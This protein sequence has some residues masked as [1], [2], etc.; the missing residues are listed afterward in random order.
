MSLVKKIRFKHPIVFFLLI[1]IFINVLIS[2]ISQSIKQNTFEKEINK[3]YELGIIEVSLISY[4]F[5]DRTFNVPVPINNQIIKIINDIEKQPISKNGIQRGASAP[6]F[7]FLFTDKQIKK[8]E[9]ILTVDMKSNI[10]K[11]KYWDLQKTQFE[12]YYEGNSNDF[13]RKIITLLN[14]SNE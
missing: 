3:L 10:I 1:I 8:I 13:Y 5:T 2:E 9:L 4:G 12:K 11:I 14:E 6:F 7:K